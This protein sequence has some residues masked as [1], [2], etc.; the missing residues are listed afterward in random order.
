MRRV[1]IREPL[2][3]EPVVAAVVAA[4]QE[5]RSDDNGAN[6]DGAATTSMT[7]RVRSG[8]REYEQNRRAGDDGEKFVTHGWEP[9]GQALTQPVCNGRTK[10]ND[11][12]FLKELRD[13]RAPL[14][15]E[16]HDS[17]VGED[18][19]RRNWNSSGPRAPS[20]V[21]SLPR[22]RPAQSPARWR[23]DRDRPCRCSSGRSACS[24]RRW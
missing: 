16:P 22:P 17:S 21:S 3:V 23:S 11:R 12:V 8:R 15:P 19:S 10:S 6:D 9:P 13:P 18:V 2:V 7:L 20:W 24:A 4:E 1:R 5:R 14:S